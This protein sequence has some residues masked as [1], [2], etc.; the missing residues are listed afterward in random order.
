M[1]KFL[2]NFVFLFVIVLLIALTGCDSKVTGF[3]FDDYT[4]DNGVGLEKEEL[5]KDEGMVIDGV[6]DEEEWEIAMS[7]AYTL[8]HTTYPDVNVTSMCYLGD[9]GVYFGVVVNDTHIYYNEERIPTRNSSVEI[10]V[11]G[12]G[13]LDTRAYSMIVAP[14]GNGCEVQLDEAT[15]RLNLN[16]TGSMQWMF[17]PFKWEGAATVKG[18]I[19]TSTNEGYVVETFIPWAELG[20]TNH[21]YVR[22]Y[23]AMNHVEG[24]ASDAGRSWS[25]DD[26]NNRPNTWRI[27]SN[28]GLVSYDE[29]MEELIGAD[30][31]MQI[32]GDL[33]EK[34]WEG[35]APAEFTYTTK[36]GSVVGLSIRSYMTDK[37]AYFGFEVADDDIYYSENRSLMFNSGMEILFA[38]YGS[39][40]ITS[41]CLQLR[42]TATNVSIGYTG[43]PGSSYPWVVNPFEML[44]ATTIQGELNTSGNEGYTIELFIPWTSFGSNSKL[45]GVMV[46]PSV[47][48]SENAID[49]SRIAPWDYCNVTNAKVDKQT[50]PSETFIYLEENGAV[51]QQMTL[52]SLFLTN[53]M[54]NGDYYE[55][56]FD[57]PAGYVNLSATASS[58]KQLVE[59]EFVLPENVKIINNGD[60][61]FTIKVHKNYIQDFEDGVEYIAS[62]GSFE[63][64]AKIYYSKVNVDGVVN[65]SGYGESVY[66]SKTYNSADN[67][68]VQK[69]STSF[70]KLGLFVGYEVTDAF[71]K[72]NTHVETFFTVGGEVGIGKTFQIRSFPLSETY[73]TYSYQNPDSSDWAWNE[74]TGDSKL[75]VF[76]KCKLTENGYMVELYIPYEEFGVTEPL[77]EIYILPVTSYYKTK[78]ASSTSQYHKENGISNKETWDITL[79]KKFDSNG[80]VLPATKAPIVEYT[81]D[82]GQIVNTGTQTTVKGQATTNDSDLNIVDINNSDLSFTNGEFEDLNG[83][84]VLNNRN[85]GGN[86]FTISN[87]EG[88][89]TGD[90]TIAVKIKITK[91]TEKTSYENYLFGIGDSKDVGKPYFNV[92]YTSNKGNM[93]I[94]LRV[95]GNNVYSQYILVGEWIEFYVVKSGNKFTLY[96]DPM[97]KYGSATFYSDYYKEVTLSDVSAI[98]FTNDCNL[99]FAS[100]AGCQDPGDYPVYYDDIRVYDYAF[101]PYTKGE[102]NG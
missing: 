33:S 38:P 34:E 89:G 44:S 4:I 52:P 22:T 59:P 11:K 26:G 14:T 1:K 79:Y 2:K 73:K 35:I 41:K 47:Y 84:L 65:D 39:K 58:E 45:D 98:N 13:D 6:L 54:L 70:G 101:E 30:E 82:N 50:N 42:I 32:D 102:T 97:C 69:V 9:K 29:I 77:E 15:R 37:G 71:V 61:T 49:N 16:A 51:L 72:N 20:V 46:C 62:C 80:Y 3:E 90:F 55:G 53:D 10:Q 68:V 83:A 92:A 17:T 7:N 87:I 76:V 5:V 40:E 96:I 81:F 48:H 43:N 36:Y 74:L 78:Q 56:T 100:N 86:H 60:K 31:Y 28:T 63:Y 67:K 12:F 91:A 64:S 94:R 57:I 75:N 25:G 23:V 95:D 99:G 19:N 18:N 85:V 66:I 24:T 93:Q 88:I 21:K 27:A 8:T